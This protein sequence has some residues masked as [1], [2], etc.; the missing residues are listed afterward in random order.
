[1]LYVFWCYISKDLLLNI[2]RF[3]NKIYYKIKK[4][5][6]QKTFVSKIVLKSVSVILE[7]ETTHKRLQ[8]LEL[9]KLKDIS[10]MHKHHQH[11]YP[12][13]SIG[14]H[15]VTQLRATSLHASVDVSQPTRPY[16]VINANSWHIKLAYLDLQVH[17]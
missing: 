12:E 14:L 6:F 4:R 7:R 10:D 13:Y 17:T 3:D 1:M 11:F 9:K 5:L 16:V 2:L 15:V 8:R